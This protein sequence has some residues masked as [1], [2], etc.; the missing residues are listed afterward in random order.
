[1]SASSRLPAKKK[2]LLRVRVVRV[3]ARAR[4]RVEVR[5]RVRFPT[6]RGIQALLS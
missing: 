3:R 4:A 2:V 5:L 6:G 1:M